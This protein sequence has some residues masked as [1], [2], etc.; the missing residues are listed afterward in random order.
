MPFAPAIQFRRQ[1]DWSSNPVPVRLR[2]RRA[3]EEVL[4]TPG[5]GNGGCCIDGVEASAMRPLRHPLREKRFPDWPLAAKSILG[6]W[7]FYAMTVVARAFL[8]RDPATVLENKSLT[9]STGIVLSFAIYLVLSLTAKGA[10]L[11]KRAAIA[12]VASFAAAAAM[13]GIL[14]YADRYQEKPQDETH[15]VSSEG[16]R[17]T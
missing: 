5:P 8:G 16:Y 17:I 12:V 3:G 14:I 6:F 7:L 4:R 13:A 1:N 15:F 10:S 9:V 2:F 11:R